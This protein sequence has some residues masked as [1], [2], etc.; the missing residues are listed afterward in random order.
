MKTKLIL[1]LMLAVSPALMAAAPTVVTPSAPIVETNGKVEILM[2]DGSARQV[3]KISGLLPDSLRVLTEDGASKIPLALLH[4]QTL[5]MLNSMK[6][7]P[8]QLQ[9]RLQREAAAAQAY[10]E[11]QAL[12]DRMI[13]EDNAR[14]ELAQREEAARQE[15]ARKAAMEAYIR[16]QQYLM[17][18][19]KIKEA[20]RAKRKA[21]LAAA[22]RERNRLEEAE[23]Q[24]QHEIE[25]ANIQ[26]KQAQAAAMQQQ[27][28]ATHVGPLAALMSPRDRALTGVDKIPDDQ[29]MVLQAW[30]TQP[31]ASFPTAASSVNQ[32]VEDERLTL[33]SW[34]NQKRVEKN[35][36]YVA[37]PG[38]GL[39][40]PVKS[41]IQ[42]SQFMG[43]HPG[44]VYKL[45]NGQSWV[46]VSD[47]T[48]QV[49]PDMSGHVKHVY[50]E[51]TFAGSTYRMIV[52]GAGEVMVKPG[53]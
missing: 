7:T 39:H 14:S 37:G 26:V 53:W 35:P 52:D 43:F 51:A 3:V 44:R 1:L 6:E 12:K 17:E 15:A 47:K 23:R 33:M 25:L 21:Q 18:A 13:A 27:A 48:T 10:R 30:L 42:G 32:L 49:Y 28:S 2:A 9:A 24:R 41:W 50:I 8:E 38:Q 19:R 5:L 34:L 45:G 11:N 4:A 40:L 31:L 22:E 46:Q 16:R 36:Q 29:Q 20:N